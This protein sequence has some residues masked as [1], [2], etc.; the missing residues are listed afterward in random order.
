MYFNLC[1]YATAKMAAN[2]VNC[3][4]IQKKGQLWPLKRKK[5]KRD[6]DALISMRKQLKKWFR[7]SSS[8]NQTKRKMKKKKD[9][10]Q[11]VLSAFLC[12]SIRTYHTVDYLNLVK[13]I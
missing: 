5:V 4:L 7:G 11:R 12:K 9:C 6:L 3:R 8:S 2:C 1:I 10:K 13:L